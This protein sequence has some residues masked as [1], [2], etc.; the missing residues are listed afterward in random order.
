M[1]NQRG[2][3]LVIVLWG[4]T[5]LALLAASFAQN[6][7]MAARRQLNAVEAAQARA[8]I[9]EA[10]A[11]ATLRMAVWRLDGTPYP[12]TL[13]GAKAT[14]RVFA[15]AGRLDL[16]H[17]P[18]PMLQS[19][20]RN[21]AG[22]PEEGDRLVAA[23][24]ARINVRPMLAVE[25]MAGLPGVT[26]ALYRRLA[27]SVTTHN[28]SGGFDWRTAGEDVLQ[29]IPGIAESQVASLLA[30]RGQSQ[31]NPDPALNDLLTRAGASLATTD[32]LGGAK[33]VTVQ[34]TLTLA[35]GA[36]ASAETLLLLTQNGYRVLQWRDG[37]S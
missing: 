10:L 26:P 15:E 36:S 3:A 32:P 5:L 18:P 16:N 22:D 19:L 23:L 29:A 1:K 30:M 20:F 8:R 37:L 35:Q 4:V 17:A 33:S 7:G 34:I 27:Q 9:D 28:A 12:L 6:T 14:V 21:V 2:I 24:A 13:S 11:A 25:E 31:Y